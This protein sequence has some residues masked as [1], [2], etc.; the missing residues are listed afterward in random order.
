MALMDKLKNWFYDA[1]GVEPKKTKRKRKKS[2]KKTKAKKKA[3]LKKKV[4]ARKTKKSTAV[5]K[6]TAKKTV[7]KKAVKKKTTKQK[8]PV[9]KKAA[10]KVP[11]KKKAPAKKS[12]KKA[13]K[14][15][16][17]PKKK[18]C[19]GTITHYFPRVN[20]AVIRVEKKISAGIQVEISGD[21]TSFKQKVSSLQINRIPVDE[22]RPGEDVGLEVKKNVNVGDKVYQA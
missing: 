5:K 19:Y 6:S 12:V 3:V 20:A 17:G 11:V 7:K 14:S 15:A 10:K 21:Q 18:L 13:V 16:A 2:A 22:G 4:T 9:K 8:A 1:L